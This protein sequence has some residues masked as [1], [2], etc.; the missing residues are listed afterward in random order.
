MQQTTHLRLAGNV[1]EIF[2][3]STWF[4]RST[5]AEACVQAIDEEFAPEAEVLAFVKANARE[6]RIGIWEFADG[7]CF[8][9]DRLLS[10]RDLDE[11]DAAIAAAVDGDRRACARRQAEFEQ[12]MRRVSL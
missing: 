3:G 8:D 9:E 6:I 5:M 11:L 2:E 10:G 1:I 4:A 7:S 12:K